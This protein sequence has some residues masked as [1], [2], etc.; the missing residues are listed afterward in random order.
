MV[1][2]QE[3]IR[4]AIFPV[5]EKYRLRAVYLF[6]SYARGTAT[7]QS[8]I[9]LLIDT[10]GTQIKSLLQLAAVYCDL[11]VALGKKVDVVT[12]SALV[13]KAQ[14]PSEESFRD[15]VWNERVNLYAV[16]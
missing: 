3:E 12:L 4:Q 10:A 16:A 8:D 14:M 9:D 1:Y 13:Q 5:A 6:G 7:E 2:T 15:Q 11:E